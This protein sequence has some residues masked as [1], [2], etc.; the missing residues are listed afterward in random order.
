VLRCAGVG[1][2]ADEVSGLMCETSSAVSCGAG[3]V[4]RKCSQARLFGCTAALC[5][6]AGYTV[7]SDGALVVGC[8]AN[9]N[10]HD[11]ILVETASGAVVAG[12]TCAGNN[13]SGGTGAGIRVGA[14]ATA[15]RVLFNNC[16]DDQLYATQLVGIRDDP[17]ARDSLV[18]FN[19]TATMCTRRGHDA[20][21]SLVVGGSGSTAGDNWTETILPSNDSLE[22]LE[23]K[24]QSKT[25][26]P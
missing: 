26:P 4:I 6:A 3:V 13:Q 24:R 9:G 12:N 10:L 25:T 23:W 22:C 7:A 18:R 19:A 1:Y 2:A 20:V 8:N 21:P 15:T 17:A 14:G 16:G 5:Q 11:G